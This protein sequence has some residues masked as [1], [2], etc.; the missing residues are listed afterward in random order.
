MD[1]L[2]SRPTWEPADEP[3]PIF[4]ELVVDDGHAAARRLPLTYPVTLLGQAAHCDVCL[5]ADE[6]SLVHCI[7][8]CSPGGIHLRDLGSATG[9]TVNGRPFTSGP[10]GR[11]DL[12]AVGPF[13][14]RVAPAAV[15]VEE[16]LSPSALEGERDALRIQAAA[17][18]AQQA[19]LAEEEN[20]LRHRSAA[21]DRQKEQ[22]A[23][24]L[25]QRRQHLLEMQAQMRQGRDALRA[26]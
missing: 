25:E 22:L 3:L 23:A 16:A 13:Q 11:G 19:A 7:L 15:P 17:V 9:T 8:S 6:V 21:F 18:V 2:E 5:Q 14:L 1:Q 12:I 24:H 26:E 10:V 20:R 4:A